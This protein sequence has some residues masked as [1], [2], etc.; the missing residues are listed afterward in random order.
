MRGIV[1]IISDLTDLKN[2]YPNIPKTCIEKFKIEEEKNKD[3]YVS[4]K[5]KCQIVPDIED[6]DLLTKI[7]PNTEDLEPLIVFNNLLDPLLMDSQSDKNN[8]SV[9]YFGRNAL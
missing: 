8:L 2:L 1:N 5:L 9:E 3:G 7:I 4:I 6:T